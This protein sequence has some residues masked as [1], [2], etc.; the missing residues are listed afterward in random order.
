MRDRISKWVCV[1]RNRRNTDW[2]WY[3][4]AVRD[5]TSSGPVYEIIVEDTGMT[6]FG[7]VDWVENFSA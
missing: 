2:T 7:G 3:L 6:W 1:R 4:I 5:R